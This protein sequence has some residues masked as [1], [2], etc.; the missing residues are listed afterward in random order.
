MGTNG[1]LSFNSSFN[2]Y[3]NSPFP[4]SFTE[5]YLVAPF[6]D[7]V[8][9]RG[10]NGRIMYEI[11]EDGYFLEQVNRF[12]QR[13]RPSSF[14]GT[15]MLVAHWDEVHPYFGATAT[16]VSIT[17]M[18]SKAIYLFC[19]CVFFFFQDN[20]FQAILITDGQYSYTIFTYKCGLMEWDNGAII[21]FNAIGGVFE[22]HDPSSSEVAC[23]NSPES[24]YSN[25]VY[26]LSNESPEIPIPGIYYLSYDFREPIILFHMQIP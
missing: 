26:L 9:I 12:L 17:I 10:G 14:E 3:F 16:T 4:L 23:L 19:V 22:N 8:D 1:I 11:H 2:S 18:S 25:I 24:E 21:G 5:A 13:K 7:D 6:W 15:W 20:T